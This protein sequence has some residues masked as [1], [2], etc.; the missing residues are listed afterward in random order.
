[1]LEEAVRT[2]DSRSTADGGPV[3]SFTEWDP[4]TEVIVGR[5]DGGVFPSWQEAMADTMPRDTWD[6]L[7]EDGAS[8]FPTAHLQAAQAELD[9][10][11]EVLTNEGIRVRRPDIVRHDQ[12]LVT[13]NWSVDGGLYSAMPRDGLMM[14][15]DTIIEA[16]M[17]WRCRYFEADA[18]RSL[19][20]EYFLR[21]ARWLAARGRSLPT[22]STAAAPTA[23]LAAGQSQSS[24]R[25]STLLILCV[26]G[27]T[28]LFSAAM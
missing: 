6:K 14:V 26:S 12:P 15:G 16:P 8:P 17:S 23:R 28:L 1:M 21:G 5:L 7:R 13:P 18:Y 2:E 3:T 20:K 10:L 4:L 27:A 9:T 24:S 25:F 11:C 22:S 19:I